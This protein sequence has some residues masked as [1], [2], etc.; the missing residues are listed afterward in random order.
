MTDFRREV[1]GGGTVGAAETGVRPASRLPPEQAVWFSSR[2]V[3][4]LSSDLPQA[5][6]L[7]MM[8]T[9]IFFVDFGAVD[10]RA[11]L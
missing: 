8:T 1:M 6:C 4:F 7:L 9:S 2:K 11:V 3:D 10:K 5:F